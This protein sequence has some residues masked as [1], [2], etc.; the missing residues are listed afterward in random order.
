MTSSAS[1]QGSAGDPLNGATRHL[2]GLAALLMRVS[3]ALAPVPTDSRPTSDGGAPYEADV[4]AGFHDVMVDLLH[5]SQEIQRL[6]DDF[7]LPSGEPAA[8]AVGGNGDGCGL[9][10]AGLAGDLA[11]DALNV[12]LGTIIEEHQDDWAA[13]VHA[14]R[15]EKFHGNNGTHDENEPL[16]LYSK[17]ITTLPVEVRR[18]FRRL[19]EWRTADEIAERHAAFELGRQIERQARQSKR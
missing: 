16:E 6:V 7:R 4:W 11:R 8:T 18:D 19:T 9:S 5:T 10:A 15:A 17:V 1:L 12:D 14:V 3:E 13:L 2:R